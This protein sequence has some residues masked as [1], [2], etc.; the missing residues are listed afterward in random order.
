MG[1][2]ESQMKVMGVIWLRCTFLQRNGEQIEP[3]HP[4]LQ[5]V[6]CR[7][8]HGVHVLVPTII[9]LVGVGGKHLTD[10]ENK[11]AYYRTV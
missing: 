9:V 7:R 10:E 8:S 2:T 5:F 3:L 6:L 11:V 4:L 1:I